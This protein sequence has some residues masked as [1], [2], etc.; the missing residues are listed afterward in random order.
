[1]I[2]K[3]GVKI[4]LIAF[5]LITIIGVTIVS[6]NYIGVGRTLLGRQYTAYVDLSDSGGVFTNAEVTY[7]GVAVGRVGPIQLTR[8][9]IKVKLLLDR[10]KRI[11]REGTS[12]VVAN[13]SAVGEQYIDLQPSK[14]TG[15]YLDEGA[16][17]TI[18][19]R[20]TKLP[21]STAELL[22]NV[23]KLVSS[24]NPQH[25]GTIVDELDKAFNG[26][27]ADLKAILDDTDRLI[28]T[29]EEAYPDTKRLLDD[30]ATV[31]NTQRA[32]GAN[33]RGFARN[34]NELTT[35]LR[36]DDPALRA[37]LDATPGTV[38]QVDKTIDGLAPTLPV[39]LA[40]MTTTGQIIASRKAGL[41]SLFILYPLTVGGAFTVTPGDGT[42]HLGLALNIDSPAPCTKGYEKVQKRW[43]QFTGDKKPR[44][45]SGCTE[46]GDSGKVVRG[47]RNFPKDAIAPKPQVPPGA[48]DGAGFP[49]GGAYGGGSGGSGGAAQGSGAEQT[50]E[51]KAKAKAE[52]KEG[53]EQEQPAAQ[54]QGSLYV[55][56][57][58]GT[59]E[60]AG[61]DPSTGVVY[62]PD[63]KRYGIGYSG[64][65]QRL[66]G[67]ASWKML[68]LGPLS[69]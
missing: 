34:L 7:R 62:G 13:R 53:K 63:G 50:P 9:G 55:P 65:Q 69:R 6:V 56:F 54:P 26:S 39:L 42:Q 23:D 11:P 27:A 5:T 29:A 31:L 38:V 32:Q 35:Q 15:P 46:P 51:A 67:D 2:L 3:R 52:G 24:V 66:L 68:L 16:P 33:I 12:A 37:T 17:Y 10:G 4:Q 45:D 30:G 22:R 14:A 21:V 1:M 49:E 64:G 28:Q 18:P 43:P 59:V 61:Y 58:S 40:N 36:R 8:D 44:L 48:T 41:R 25:L 60:L 57:S 20:L 19:R 47:A